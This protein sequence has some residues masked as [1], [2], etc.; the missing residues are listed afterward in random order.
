MLDYKAV[1]FD[2]DGT[3]VNTIND[4]TNSM[5]RVLKS[6]NLPI[7][8]LSKYY[9][10]VGA[11]LKEL[12]KRALPEEMK[13]EKS[14]LHYR[15]LFNQDYDQNWN[16]DSRPYEGISDL[17]AYLQASKKS[18][19]VLSN[20]P[21]QFCKTMINF[22]FSEINFSVI[23]G[24][25]DNIP[26]KPHPAGGKIVLEILGQKAKDVLFVGDTNIDMQTAKNCGFKAIG[27]EWG[28]RTKE[29]LDRAGA[30]ITFKR[31]KDFL[32]Y[33]QEKI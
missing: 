24:N 30:D 3:L 6:M 13:D 20:K 29:E 23:R 12:C 4:I 31:P 10:F 22:Y 9:Y 1:I 5:N 32:T 21:D 28:F 26:P 15:D 11:G 16:I 33:L 18:I 14:V 25:V 2:L 27:A 8:D 19:A 17:L 7:H